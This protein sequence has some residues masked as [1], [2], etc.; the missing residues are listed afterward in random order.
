[1]TAM[2]GPSLEIARIQSEI[3][4]LFESLYDL[5]QVGDSAEPFWMPNTDIVEEPDVL[6]LLVD[7]P[8]VSAADLRL[9]ADG[10][11]IIIEGEKRRPQGEPEVREHHMLERTYGRFRRVI[12]LNYPINTHRARARLADG[13]LRIEFPKVEN[14]RGGA[15]A[16]SLEEA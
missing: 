10:G 7:L 8:G 16:I 4:R 2:R 5:R 11:N 3:N 6:V 1:M 9:L 13:V 15:V 14:R 12:S